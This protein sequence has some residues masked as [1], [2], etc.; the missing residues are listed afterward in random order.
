MVFTVTSLSIELGAGA[1]CVVPR[2]I[3]Q[4]DR[5]QV[6]RLATD[7]LAL[8]VMMVAALSAAGQLTAR[9]LFALL[10]AEGVVLDH[11]VSTLGPLKKAAA[12][13]GDCCVTPEGDRD[14]VMR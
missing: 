4:G 3:G 11:I 5:D 9:P 13:A 14:P 10:G 1:A 7:S 2:A 8:A 12:A 6:R